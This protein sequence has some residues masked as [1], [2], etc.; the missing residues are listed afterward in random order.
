MERWADGSNC[1]DACNSELISWYVIYFVLWGYVI[2]ILL[3]AHDWIGAPYY[4]NSMIFSIDLNEKEKKFRLKEDVFGYQPI[5]SPLSTFQNLPFN[6]KFPSSPKSLEWLSDGHN[7][8]FA[9]QVFLGQE[10]EDCAELS[11]QFPIDLI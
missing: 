8:E 7:M 1:E 11:H 3:V 9:A 2:G 4:N 5:S 10:Q 6:A